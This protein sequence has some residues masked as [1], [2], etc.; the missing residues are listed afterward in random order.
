V[1]D[2]FITAGDVHWT[3]ESSAITI[4]GSPAENDL[5]LFRVRRVPAD[6]ADTLGVDAKLI[7]IRLFIATNAKNDA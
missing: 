2:T 3:A 4:A 6:A 7:A 5:V 1:T